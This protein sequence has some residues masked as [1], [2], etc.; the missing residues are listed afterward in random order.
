MFIRRHAALRVAQLSVADF[1]HAFHI[2]QRVL[3]DATLALADSDAS[4]RAVLG[5][6]TYI[7]RY[8]DTATTH[9]A[10]VYL[11]AEQL[12]S[13]TGERLRRDVLENLIAGIVPA[14]GPRLEALLQA[15][16]RPHGH[17]LVIAAV[18]VEA[19][20]DVH[21]L[22]SAAAALGRVTRQ[23]VSPLTVVRHDEIVVVSS[24]PHEDLGA[25]ATRLTE[26][27]QRLA[28]Q[29][30]ALAVGMSTVHEGLAGV[31]EAYRE[32]ADARDLLAPAAGV[33][34]L[35]AMSAFDYLVSYS[36]PTVRRLIPLQIRRFVAQDAAGGGTLVAT[37]RAYA[38]ANLN[39]RQAAADLHVHVN[40]AH[41]RLARIEERTGADLR[42]LDD[43]IE[44][45]IAARLTEAC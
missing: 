19:P 6:V 41:Y 21:A 25:P 32:A 16:L 8:F 11:E 26:V 33:V 35:P 38:A 13:A 44:L 7:V 40:T 42:M 22:R 4:R 18:P 15:G 9:A 45:L 23:A 24:A 10:E 5:L 34:A 27:Q 29:G 31:P 2:G 17:C 28:E 1:I 3:W 14:P 39:V 36:N 12:L 20:E 30:L 37:L 43:V